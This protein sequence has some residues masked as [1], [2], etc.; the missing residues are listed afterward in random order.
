[1]SLLSESGFSIHGFKVA[2]SSDNYNYL[3]ACEQ[4]GE[5][6]VIDP[7]DPVTLLKI[8]RERNYRVRYVVNTHGHPDHIQG[9][10]PITKVFLSSKIL[11]HSTA[12]KIRI[13]K[14]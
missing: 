13:S 5:C 12:L 10:D 2:Q 4:T 6:V 8:I 14:K 7:L 3:V 11:I 9:N 1:M